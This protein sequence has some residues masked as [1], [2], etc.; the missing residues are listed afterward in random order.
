MFVRTTHDV[1]QQRVEIY[2]KEVIAQI[3]DL[4]YFTETGPIGGPIIM[5]QVRFSNIF[6]LSKSDFGLFFLD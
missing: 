2:L 4:Q 6:S 1:Y 3:Q 5:V